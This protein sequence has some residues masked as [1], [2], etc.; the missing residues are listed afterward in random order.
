MRSGVITVIILLASII[1]LLLGFRTDIKPQRHLR[2]Y[3]AGLLLVS[4]P[5][6][7]WLIWHKNMGNINLD[8]PIL[9]LNLNVILAL[10]LL[11]FV[12]LYLWGIVKKYIGDRQLSILLPIFGIGLFAGFSLILLINGATE[13]AKFSAMSALIASVVLLFTKLLFTARFWSFQILLIA[14]WFLVSLISSVFGHNILGKTLSINTLLVLLAFMNV[15]LAVFDWF[16]NT[17]TY[18]AD[19][20][21][22]SQNNDL[23]YSAKTTKVANS[24]VTKP[25]Q[26]KSASVSNYEYDINKVNS[27]GSLSKVKEDATKIAN[28]RP[29]FSVAQSNI[30]GRTSV[31]SPKQT[32]IYQERMIDTEHENS[33]IELPHTVQ[34]NISSSTTEASTKNSKEDVQKI[35]Q[36]EPKSNSEV[37]NIVNNKSEKAVINDQSSSNNISKN[38]R[39]NTV[40][41]DS[42]M[43]NQD[44]PNTNN[45]TAKANSSKFRMPKVHFIP[46]LLKF[47]SKSDVDHLTKENNDFKMPVFGA[48]RK[49]AELHQQDNEP[50]FSVNLRTGETT[51]KNGKEVTSSSSLNL[52][53]SLP[54]IKSNLNMPRT[55]F[56]IKKTKNKN[57]QKVKK[58]SSQ[59]VIPT[60]SLKSTAWANSK[61]NKLKTSQT[62]SVS[63]PNLGSRVTASLILVS[64]T[65]PRQKRPVRVENVSRTKL[66]PLNI[67]SL[68]KVV[69]KYNNSNVGKYIKKTNLAIP[70]R[71][72]ETL[73]KIVAYKNSLLKRMTFRNTKRLS[74]IGKEQDNLLIDRLH[75]TTRSLSTN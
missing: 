12:G 69:G 52:K 70:Y 72:Q 64:Q 16:D 30:D 33:P 53:K 5:S 32:S 42:K 40:I 57:H 63:M 71:S 31:Y 45:N 48:T 50:E 39:K 35:N 4:I 29:G 58:L 19:Y 9:G 28:T 75:R 54:K 38:I 23:E 34:Q 15:F 43:P 21:D 25:K 11:P 55:N 62:H 17:K 22:V 24:D 1:V 36:Y 68:S 73:D 67:D 26:Y 2:G 74:Y 37:N 13:F 47:S 46:K 56:A 51:A 14:V 8:G 7:I 41:V 6:A 27:Y 3:L 59:K 66:T 18:L 20:E 49:N 44:E 60:N 61:N 10:V 65:K